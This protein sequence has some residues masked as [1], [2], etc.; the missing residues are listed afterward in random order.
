[1]LCLSLLTLFLACT[2][3]RANAQQE[4]PPPEYPGYFGEPHIVTKAVDFAGPKLAPSD[5][6]QKDGFYPEL[7]N[8]ITGA[9]WI[10]AGPGYR[11]K[12]LQERGLV[13]ASAAVSWRSYTIAQTRAE[14][15]PRGDKRLVLGGQGFWQDATQ[16][17]YYGLGPNSSENN[18][19]E[20]RMRSVDVVGWGQTTVKDVTITGTFGWLRRP[21]IMSPAGP[22]RSGYA[23]AR[24]LFGDQ[25]A[26]GLTTPAGFLH[27]G[28]DAVFDTRD[29]PHHPTHGSLARGAWA[30]YHDRDTGQ[31]NFQ[32]YEAEGLQF[33]PIPPRN[34]TLAVHGWVVGSDTSAGHVVPIYLM[35]SLGGHNTLPGYLD[36]RFHDRNMLLLG[37]ES[38]WALWQH[39]DAALFFDA[40][41]VA[42]R[43]GDLNLR[44]TSVGAG[45]R[46]HTRT[47]TF[48]R[49]D[50]G[51]SK[52]GWRVFFKLDDPL[53]L[54]RRA[55]HAPT[56]PFVP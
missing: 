28:V 2:A 37:A 21:T 55:R 43:F 6:P 10:S 38:R 23:D 29:E 11:H 18:R 13:D 5:G 52:E 54:T 46:V 24:Q 51:H 17:R 56:V 27:G 16:I 31:F 49:L 25:G 41:N 44:K 35:P 33:I 8:M 47:A 20:Y 34:W 15:R 45:L 19:T 4:T 53:A 39:L 7:G 26:P 14:F 30:A 50:F 22:F 32:R 48:G 9:G 12:F 1:M 42:P 36:Y 40:G 3:A